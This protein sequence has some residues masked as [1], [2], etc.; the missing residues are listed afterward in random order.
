MNTPAAE[1]MSM[2]EVRA[3][4]DALDRRIIA[5]LQE[6]TAYIDRAGELK[7]QNGLPAR[8][9]DRVEEVMA[10]ARRTAGENGLDPDLVEQVWQ[11]L[12]DWSIER[13]ARILRAVRRAQTG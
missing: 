3:A 10:N 9:F 13:E 5:L 11:L 1:C 7:S 2:A 6:R 4:I 8:I 12:V